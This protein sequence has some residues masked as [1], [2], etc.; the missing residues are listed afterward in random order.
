MHHP[1]RSIVPMLALLACCAC[2]TP[3]VAVV[4]MDGATGAFETP[5]EWTAFCE[6]L[7]SAGGLVLREGLPDAPADRAEAH[8]YLLQRLVASIEEVL[9]AETEPPVVALYSH[10]LRKYGMDSADAKY[11]TVRLDPRGTYRLYG[12]LGSAHHVA[13]Q[14]VSNAEGY[15]AF[16][17]LALTE[18]RDRGETELD[19]RVSAARPEGWTGAWLPIDPRARELLIRE[20]FYDWDAETPSTFLVERLD[21]P[22]KA[23]RLDAATIERQL[24]AIA[25]TFEATVPKWLPASLDDRQH[26]VNQLRPPA[27]SAREG[28]R[29]NA[30]GSGWFRLRPGEALL[31][32]LDEPDAHLWSFELGDFWWQSID[33]VNHTSSLNGFQA[34]R[35]ADGRYRLVLSLE[36]PGVPN[37]L[38]PAGHDEGVI[39]YRYQLAGG[40]TPVPTTRLVRLSELA[41]WLPEETPRVTP[42]ARREEIRKRRAHAAR[43]WAP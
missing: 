27:T 3:A 37:W 5:A 17:S 35:S 2:R 22:A 1:A 10:K 42:A 38:D 9:E 28:I 18:L 34:H 7:A 15:A 19:V 21:D 40:A 16:D 33:Y 12:E 39:I 43:R 6:R 29:E 11:S 26:R 32:E 14:L 41:S 8:R 25:S 30:Y 31:I 24:E 4:A 20:Y 13:L 36:D 23:A